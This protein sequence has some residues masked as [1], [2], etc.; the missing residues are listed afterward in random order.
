MSI[1]GSRSELCG[2]HCADTVGRVSIGG[3]LESVST[4]T[5]T[6]AATA[7]TP[8]AK[9]VYL[10]SAYLMGAIERRSACVEISVPCLFNSAENP[11]PQ[12]CPHSESQDGFYH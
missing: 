6:T 1:R 4:T 12:M 7:A 3:V 9:S 5:Q 11:D 10:T 8:R 2:D